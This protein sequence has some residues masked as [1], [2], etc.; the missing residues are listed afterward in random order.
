MRKIVLLA[1]TAVIVA[2]CI[3]SRANHYDDHTPKV[4]TLFSCEYIHYE[5][6]TSGHYEEL[7]IHKGNCKFCAERRKA[8][9]EELVKRIKEK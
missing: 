8:E 9:L 6:Y 3:E 5:S 1:L 7:Y 4:V 2:G